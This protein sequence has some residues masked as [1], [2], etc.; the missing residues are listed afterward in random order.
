MFLMNLQGGGNL[1]AEKRALIRH[2]L[3][4]SLLDGF[5]GGWLEA[6]IAS[7]CVCV[8]NSESVAV[9]VNTA[10]RGVRNTSGREGARTELRTKDL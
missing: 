9:I 4:T 5:F 1:D 6:G 7:V 2:V 8:W 3:Y 10:V